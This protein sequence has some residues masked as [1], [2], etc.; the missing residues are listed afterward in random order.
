MVCKIKVS[1]TR[2]DLHTKNSRP[3]RRLMVAQDTGGAIRGPVRGDVYWGAGDRA[4]SIAGR[5]KNPGVYWMLLPKKPQT[6]KQA[7]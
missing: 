3:F 4:T 7:P 2:P 1:E 5:M 6:D